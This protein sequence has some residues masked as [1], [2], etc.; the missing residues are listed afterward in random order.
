MSI[1]ISDLQNKTKKLSVVFQDETINIEYKVNVVTPAFLRKEHSL[2]EQLSLAIVHWDVTDD[3]GNEAEP[4]VELFD[5]LPIGF[6]GG[7]MRAITDDMRIVG[8]DEKKD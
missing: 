6:Q 3:D 2:G 5:S 1:K 8:D 4:S 7:L